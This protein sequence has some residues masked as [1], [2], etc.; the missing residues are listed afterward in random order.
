MVTRGPRGPLGPEVVPEPVPGSDP[1]S[2][3]DPEDLVQCPYDKNHRVRVSRLPYHLV[4]CQRNN[5]GIA[6]SLTTCPFNARHRV[7]QHQLRSHLASCPD[8]HLSS[9]PPEVENLEDPLPFIFDG[10]MNDLLL[11]HERNGDSTTALGSL[12]QCFTTLS[13][14]EFF[15]ISNLNFPWCNLRPFLLIPS[16]VPGSRTLSRL[17]P[18]FLGAAESNELGST[19]KPEERPGCHGGPRGPGETVSGSSTWCLSLPQGLGYLGDAPPQPLLRGALVPRGPHGAPTAPGDEKSS[20][21]AVDLGRHVFNPFMELTEGL[22]PPHRS[23]WR[24]RMR[25]R[26][27]LSHPGAAEGWS[28]SAMRTWSCWSEARGDH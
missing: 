16:L 7:P 3:M 11:V 14:K 19:H 20:E 10:S 5:P 4:K 21:E 25:S 2:A 1:D 9:L 28:S 17:T 8:Q 13:M 23:T 24:I 22:I 27:A 12:C 6:R 15:P 26:L 18:A